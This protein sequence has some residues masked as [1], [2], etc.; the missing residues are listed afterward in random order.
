LTLELAIASMETAR[1]GFLNGCMAVWREI[2][3]TEPALAEEIHH[4][5][6]DDHVAAL[7]ICTPNETNGDC[8]ARVVMAGHGAELV[9][10]IRQT[11]HGFGA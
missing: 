8:P 10:R 4:L 1:R 3:R 7:W 6:W 5:G 9:E 11:L 2:E